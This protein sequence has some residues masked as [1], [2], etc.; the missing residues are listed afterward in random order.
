[1]RS[2]DTLEKAKHQQDFF[3]DKIA[4]RGYGRNSLQ[5]LASA[6]SR[7][8]VQERKVFATCTFS[9]TVNTGF[10]YNA[11]DKC[12]FLLASSMRSIRLVIAF[13]QQ[14]QLHAEPLLRVMGNSIW[15]E[16][17]SIQ[18]IRAGRDSDF[19]VGRLKNPSPFPPEWSGWRRPRTRSNCP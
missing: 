1:M 6:R 15:C 5:K 17:S 11:F 10:I 9:S 2:N 16:A 13:R 19:L 14:M 12:R 3:L 4:A 8:S 7:P 18:T